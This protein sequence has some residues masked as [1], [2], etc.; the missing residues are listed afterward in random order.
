MNGVDDIITSTFLSGLINIDEM[1]ARTIA[2]PWTPEEPS[3]PFD[4]DHL[5]PDDEY[6]EDDEF[7]EFDG[8]NSVFDGFDVI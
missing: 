4:F 2:A 1:R 6:E 5:Q 8:D 3:E 7:D